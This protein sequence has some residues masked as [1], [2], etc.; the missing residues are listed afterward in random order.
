MMNSGPGKTR[1]VMI[2]LSDLDMKVTMSAL[3]I[4][5][6]FDQEGLIRQTQR[7]C[8]QLDP[9]DVC[10]NVL[11]ALMTAK[12]LIGYLTEVQAIEFEEKD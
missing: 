1:R 8:P 12:D 2:E 9:D 5:T 6:G 10:L 7:D 4:M 3:R 11:T